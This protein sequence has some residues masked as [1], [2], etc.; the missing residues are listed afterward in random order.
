VALRSDI[1]AEYVKALNALDLKPLWWSSVACP[2]LKYLW[3]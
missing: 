3:T 2:L 1:L